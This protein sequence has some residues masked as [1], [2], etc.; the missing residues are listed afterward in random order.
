VAQRASSRGIP[1]FSWS[2][3]DPLPEAVRDPRPDL[4]L[5][6]CFPR[7][8]P[9]EVVGLAR[10]DCLNLHPSLLPRYRG[11]APLFW[12][13]RAGET[14]T[15]V[16][17]HRI[18]ARL[19]AGEL[20]AQRRVALPEGASGSE[21]EGL[22]G[23]EGGGLLLETVAAAPGGA[24]FAR[25]QD[26]ALASH[27]PLPAPPDFEVPTT[28]SARRAFNFIRGTGEWGYPY[29]VVSPGGRWQVSAA[30]R[31][32]E[33]RLSILSEHADGRLHIQFLDGILEVVQD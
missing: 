7:R 9:P 28:W 19:D 20:I 8:L 5:V 6:A 27:Q 13:L 4:I 17:L 1:V 2:T 32:F 15:G 24:L 11:P 21:L 30:T 3:G 31:W 12:Q 29:A 23:E 26:E 22:L 16:T 25:P 18:T 14:E 33:G 10:W